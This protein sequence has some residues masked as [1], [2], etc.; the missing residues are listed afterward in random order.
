MRP[1]TAPKRIKVRSPK[2]EMSRGK[3]TA[4]I[5]GTLLIMGMVALYFATRMDSSERDAECQTLFGMDRECVVK[6]A[7]DRLGGRYY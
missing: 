3:Q 5:V 7:A 6:N 1:E 2:S 4:W